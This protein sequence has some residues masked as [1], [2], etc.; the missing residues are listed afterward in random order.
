[1]ALC[2]SNFSSSFNCFSL[3]LNWISSSSIFFWTN[4][5]F[6]LS[7][8]SIASSLILLFS[9]TLINLKLSIFRSIFKKKFWI[10]LSIA[11]KSNLK[12]NLNLDLI[13]SSNLTDFEIK[14]S[15]FI[16]FFPDNIFF[17]ILFFIFFLI[18]FFF[19]V[20]FLFFVFLKIDNLFLFFFDFFFIFFFH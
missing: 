17:L 16:F 15:D 8:F 19:I 13:F 14:L 11:K 20:D 12:L 5:C 7:D 10:N 6:S 18:I 1:M 9:S 4:I 2:F 3:N